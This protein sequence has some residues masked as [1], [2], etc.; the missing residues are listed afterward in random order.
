MNDDDDIADTTHGLNAIA[1]FK[2]GNGYVLSLM[3]DDG[4]LHTFTLSGPK[5]RQVATVIC[6][7]IQGIPSGPADVMRELGYDGGTPNP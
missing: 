2:H 3:D 6:N 1:A 4:E 5:L 7:A